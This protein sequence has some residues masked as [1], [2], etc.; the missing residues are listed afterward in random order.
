MWQQFVKDYLSFS[1]GE[2]RAVLVLLALV[3]LVFV[4]PYWWPPH[5]DVPPGRQ[6]MQQ[7]QRPIAGPAAAG[8]HGGQLPANPPPALTPRLFYFDPNTLVAEGWQQLG[9]RDKTIRTILH[10]REKGGYFHRPEDMARIYGLQPAEYARLLPWIKIVQPAYAAINKSGAKPGGLPYIP[11][12]PYTYAYPFK[13][14]LPHSIDVNTADTSAFIALP[15][16]G[17]R[18]ASRIINFRDK[19]GGF[20]CVEQVGETYALPD[21]VFQQIKNTL[22]CDTSVIRRININTADASLLK[23]H[24]YIR[25]NMA[26]AIVAYRAQHGDYKS[27]DD[28]QRV[29][30]IT[31]EDVQ[32]LRLYLY[33]P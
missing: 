10:Y 5:K 6:A 2:R 12:K 17:S 16:I 15:G 21:S 26:N 3:L 28:L 25:W 19:L 24:P 30:I 1:K 29:E 14:V 20:Y 33:V 18:L 11:Y 4:L 9:L 32:R 13:K 7:W 31:A 27:L 23:Q 22:W 8:T